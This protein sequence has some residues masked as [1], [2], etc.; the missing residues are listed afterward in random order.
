M[1]DKIEIRDRLVMLS[2]RLGRPELDYVILGEGNSSAKIDDQTFWVKASGAE[3]RTMTGMDV[4]EVAFAPVL[5][6]LEGGDL[7]DEEVKVRLT[8]AKVDANVT[9]RPSV[10]TVLHAL[11]LTLGEASWVGHTHPTAVNALLCSQAAQEAFAGRLFPDEI[12]VCG[13][14]PAYVPYTDPGVPL[15]RRVREIMLRYMDEWGQPPRLILMQNH[16]IIALGR[17]PQQVLNITAM[18]AKTARILA[19]T[20][21][22]GGP[23]FLSPEAAERIHTRPDE[24][25]R[26]R[27]LQA[28]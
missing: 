11:A 8:A 16:G 2:R 7:N 3:M 27:E 28:E 15:A 10:E 6:M 21:S 23:H 25:Y 12:V 22:L 18:A 5:E 13:P 20:Y 26:R 9:A 17:S 19:G 4:V 14:A 24:A 1:T